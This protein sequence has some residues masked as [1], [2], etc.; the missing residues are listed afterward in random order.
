MKKGRLG[1]VGDVFEAPNRPSYSARDIS[2]QNPQSKHASST[3]LQ[4]QEPRF[5]I[6]PSVHEISPYFYCFHWHCVWLARRRT[7][8][9]RRNGVP[10]KSPHRRCAADCET[11]RCTARLCPCSELSR[12]ERRWG[13]DMVSE[14]FTKKETT[15]WGDIRQR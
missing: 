10:A 14:C 2:H 15:A 8:Y 11:I 5:G 4:I 12:W 7:C 3:H 1:V 13:R 9:C 6:P